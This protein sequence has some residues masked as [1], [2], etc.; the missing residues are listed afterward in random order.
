LAKKAVTD[1]IKDG[2]NVIYDTTGDSGISKL[3]KKCLEMRAAGAT[4]IEGHYAFPGSIEE[5]Y[6]RSMARYEH[7]SESGLKRYVD[8]EVIKNSHKDVACTWLNAAKKGVFDKLT[9]WSTDVPKGAKPELIAEA[10]GGN[11]RIHDENLYNKFKS[12]S[13]LYD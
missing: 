13:G 1:G 2:Y 12:I 5:A 9:L 11:V 6:S 3:E 4:R 7:G 8:P 10:I